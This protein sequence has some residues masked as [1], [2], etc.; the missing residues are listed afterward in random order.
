[1]YVHTLSYLYTM[2]LDRINPRS[3][4]LPPDA[5]PNPPP[6]HPLPTFM[7]SFVFSYFLFGSPLN[8]AYWKVGLASCKSPW[9][10]HVQ[11]THLTEP[12]RIS[13]ILNSSPLFRDAPWA[14]GCWVLIWIPQL[15]WS[16][17]SLTPCTL[18]SYTVSHLEMVVLVHHDT[19]QSV[20]L[21]VFPFF[22]LWPWNPRLAH[23][24]Q[25]FYLQGTPQPKWKHFQA[26]PSSTLR[27]WVFYSMV[28]SF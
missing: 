4:P 17:K 9:P 23:T 20:T 19:R 24:R 1:M 5:T 22:W 18:A 16:A 8:A 10:C 6:T 2:H 14:L 27:F 12:F 21:K 11:N 15:G 26:V 13:Q 25:R 3:F 7:S 28:G